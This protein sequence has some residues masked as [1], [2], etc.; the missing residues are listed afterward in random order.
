MRLG[1]PL[2]GYGKWTLRLL[3][4]KVVELKIAETISY[5]TIRQTLKKI[6]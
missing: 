4:R 1:S 5:E 3:A 2:V 6:A